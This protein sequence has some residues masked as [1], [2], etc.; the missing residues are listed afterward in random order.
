MISKAVKN[1]AKKVSQS[2]RRSKC[3]D[4][5]DCIRELII[6]TMQN[7][8]SDKVDFRLSFIGKYVLHSTCSLYHH[9][10][11]YYRPRRQD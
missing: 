4:A 2:V 7:V 3:P 9:C 10:C 6:P 11:C 1:N 8:S 5:A